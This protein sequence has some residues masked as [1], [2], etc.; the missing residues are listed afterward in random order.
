MEPN[1][2]S[3]TPREPLSAD[4]RAELERLRA[5]ERALAAARMSSGQSPPAT[6]KSRHWGRTVAAVILIALGCTL[7]PLSVTS[8]WA[9]SM[10]TDTERYV[11]TVAPLAENPVI[12]RTITTDI[13]R[14]VFTYIDVKGLTT[15]A[16]N[17][18][19]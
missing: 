18:L 8:V 7:V 19:A 9:R 1:A 5:E 17:G 4:E 10:V 2:D 13:T 14:R 15:Q 11:D 12:Q 16:L 3:P 6:K